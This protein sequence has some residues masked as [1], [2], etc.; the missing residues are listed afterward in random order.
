MDFSDQAQVVDARSF[1]GTST[2]SIVLEKWKPN[3]LIYIYV[4]DLDGADI[5]FGDGMNNGFVWA[6]LNDVVIGIKQILTS[7]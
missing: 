6:N 3:E 5:D 1:D 4:F 7:E 2:A